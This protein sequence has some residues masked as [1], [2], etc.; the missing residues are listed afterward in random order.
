MDVTDLDALETSAGKLGLQM[1]R[2]QRYYKW[3][4]RYV[5]DYPLPKGFAASDL[6]KCDHALTQPDNPNGYEVGIVKRKDKPGWALMWDFYNHGHGLQDKIGVG[7]RK[8]I[9]RY[10]A[11]VAAKEARRKGFRVQEQV[12]PDGRI[13]LRC[14]Q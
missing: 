14:V 8:L 2:F 4:G 1:K 7:G 12:Q 6:G 3:Y 5:G 11:E 9:Q 13:R 10:A